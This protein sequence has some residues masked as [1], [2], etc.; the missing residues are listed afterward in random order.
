MNSLKK[1]KEQETRFSVT[2]LDLRGFFPDSWQRDLVR[3]R[4]LDQTD[5]VVEEILPS[6]GV[7]DAFLYPHFGS[8]AS[9]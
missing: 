7:R 9:K 2:A 8:V 3:C 6:G 1:K 5:E 4:Q